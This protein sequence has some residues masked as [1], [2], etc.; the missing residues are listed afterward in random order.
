EKLAQLRAQ[1]AD[2]ASLPGDLAAEI[3]RGEAEL[4]RFQQFLDLTDRAH[5]AETSPLTERELSLDESPGKAK[6]PP[7]TR[8]TERR[9][10]TAVPFHREA[11]Q[12]FA[13]LEHDNWTNLLED[14]FLGPL[15]V[16]QIRRLAY[17]GLLWLADDVLRWKLEH[18]TGRTL[19][20]EAAARQALLYLDKA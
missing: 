2:D 8:R 19:S 9:N 1:L 13:V 10:V 16:E 6:T 17:E 4:D 7:P 15:Q 12:R 11:L 3:A 14:G 20:P 18:A 5:Q